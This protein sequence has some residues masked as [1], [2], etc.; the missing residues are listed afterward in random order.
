M[1]VVCRDSATSDFHTDLAN[2]QDL[3]RSMGLAPLSSPGYE[4]DDVIGTITAQA[5]AQ[6]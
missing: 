3:L 2:L 4:A 1:T 5:V 6:G